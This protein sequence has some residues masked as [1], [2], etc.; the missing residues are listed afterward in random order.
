MPDET[1]QFVTKNLKELARLTS[2]K[3]DRVKSLLSRNS[4]S[5]YQDTDEGKELIFNDLYK[6]IENVSNTPE[7]TFTTNKNLIYFTV[8]LSEEYLNL[9][10]SCLESILNNTQYINFDVLFITD[11]EY[12]EKLLT[13]SI[14]KKINYYFHL[15]PSPVTGPRASLQKIYIYDFSLINNYENIFYLDCDIVFIKDINI[16][17][18]LP[19]ATEKLYTATNKYTNSYSICSP[20]HGLMYLTDRDAEFLALNPD[21]VKPFNAGQFIFKNSTRMRKH[22]ENVKWLAENWPGEF[23][24][25]QS[26]MN[27]YFALNNL[28]ILISEAFLKSYIC[29]TNIDV[30]AT[31]VKPPPVL[32]TPPSVLVVTGAINTSCP[33]AVPLKENPYTY[34]SN[35]IVPETEDA[36]LLHFSGNPLKGEEK[37][38]K[39]TD[40]LKKNASM[41]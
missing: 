26:I 30:V 38:I 7:Q 20:T 31:V 24:F 32:V 27:H 28:N 18:N 37:N 34:T 33:S 2:V 39:I 5:V 40:Y 11:E 41:L 4:N 23:F 36:V 13:K 3:Y 16:I 6:K 19:F 29:I 15:V 21:K 10:I 9:A 12:K 17:L 25:E 22:F 8:F 1:N 14:L 35:W